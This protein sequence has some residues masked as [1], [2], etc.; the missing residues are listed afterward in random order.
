ME[1]TSQRTSEQDILSGLQALKGSRL[2]QEQQEFFDQ[3]R[4]SGK[5][6]NT[7]KNYKTDIDCFN[8][9]LIET[10]APLDLNEFNDVRVSAYGSFLQNK[11]SSDN[12]RRRR[13]QALRLFF[14]FL[15]GKGLYSENPIRKLPSSPKFLDIPRPTSYSEVQILWDRLCVDANDPNLIKKVIGIRNQIIF[16]LVYT[17]GLKVSDLSGLKIDHIESN[18]HSPRVLVTPRKRDPYSVPIHSLFYLIYKDYLVRLE[19]A[20][21]YSS[22]TFD[23]LLFNANPFKIL[24]GGLSPR[25]LELIFEDFRNR[26]NITVTP[27]SLRQ[28]CI[29]H[30]LCKKYNDGLIKDWMGVAPS[31]SLKLYKKHL[32]NHLYGDEFLTATYAEKNKGSFSKL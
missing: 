20:K 27:K 12:S 21:N 13:L 30:W 24:K 9:F 25:G 32:P 16:L 22:V 6:I 1:N 29:F 17:S 3:L 10:K 4:N 2:L 19:E 14:D 26:M 31:Y 18:P 7:L 11:Y 15:V 5:S 8:K 23:N 28:A